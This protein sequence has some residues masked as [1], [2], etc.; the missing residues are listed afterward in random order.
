MTF[1]QI[2]LTEEDLKKIEDDGIYSMFEDHQIMGRGILDAEV[3]D[4][5]CEKF[6]RYREGSSCD[7]AN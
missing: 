1:L 7:K 5:R 2:A 3:V 6:L 4:I